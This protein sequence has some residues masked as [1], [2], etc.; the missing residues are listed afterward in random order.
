MSKRILFQGILKWRRI[1]Y[2]PED[3]L[4]QDSKGTSQ[5]AAL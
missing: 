4:L 1:A 2:R 3:T 5:V